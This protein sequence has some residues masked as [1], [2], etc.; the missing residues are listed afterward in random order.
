MCGN[1]IDLTV[2]KAVTEAFG[3]RGIGSSSFLPGGWLSMFISGWFDAIQMPPSNDMFIQLA[4]S[5]DIF[6]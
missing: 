1:L 6:I 4:I 3:V 2:L 5:S